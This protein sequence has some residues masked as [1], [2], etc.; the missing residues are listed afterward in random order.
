M[1][2]DG[3]DQLEIASWASAGSGRHLGEMPPRP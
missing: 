1:N 2:G 3:F